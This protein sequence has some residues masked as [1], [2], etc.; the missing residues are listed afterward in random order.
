MFVKYTKQTRSHT[1]TPLATITRSG[2][3]VLNV[4]STRKF[5]LQ[6]YTTV[7]LWYDDAEKQIGITQDGNQ[8]VSHRKTSDVAISLRGFLSYWKILP[9]DTQRYPVTYDE[10]TQMLIISLKE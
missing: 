5:D 4:E 10:E 1:K 7:S 3:C 9:E 2:V 6:N 8:R